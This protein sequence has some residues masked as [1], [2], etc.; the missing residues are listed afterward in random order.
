LIQV[1]PV[2]VVAPQFFAGKVPLGVVSQSAGAFNHILSDLSIIVNQFEQ[3]SAFSAAVDRLSA[4]M[5][6]IKEA[7]P[8]RVSES[9]LMA[10]PN[11]TAIALEYN[12]SSIEDS[13]GRIPSAISLTQYE[14]LSSEISSAL[15][16]ADRR[17]NLLTIDNVSLT[18]PDRKRTLVENLDLNL[19]WGDHLLIVGNSGAGKSSLLRAVAGLWTAGTGSIVRPADEDVYF[20]PQRPYCA[21]GSLKDQLLYPS[22]EQSETGNDL[23]DNKNGIEDKPKSRVLKK[24]ISDDDLLAV[25]DAVNLSD[26][27]VRAGDGDPIKGLNA[28]M[29]WSNTLSLGEQQRLAFGRIL[30]NE[31]RL[32]ILD[33]ATS[34]LDMEGEAKMYKLLEEMSNKMYNS[35][36]EKMTYVSV[37]HRPSLLKY[38]DKRLRL[39]GDNGFS[40]EDISED[41]PV[42][43][44][45]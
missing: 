34:A 22:I 24:S 11:K 7:D 14:P 44:N 8:D 15:D 28:I 10:L 43:A 41:N 1:L 26:L 21:L 17:N 4:F 29:D 12:F 6:A 38:H 45:I 2:A 30:V 42:V 27:P 13:V 39:M 23:D 33:E 20:L 35:K 25:F 3:L 32:V 5:T 40:V 16:P 36:D 9:P 19:Q 37:G 18:T 31:P